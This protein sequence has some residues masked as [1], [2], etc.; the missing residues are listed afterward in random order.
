MRPGRN[1]Y[2][3]TETDKTNKNINTEVQSTEAASCGAIL[4]YT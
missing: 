1:A 2:I 3:L 4:L